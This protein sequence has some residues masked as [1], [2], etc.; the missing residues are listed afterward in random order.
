MSNAEH[1]IENAICTI[2]RGESFEDFAAD[3][4]NQIMSET[5]GVKLESVWDMAQYVIYTYCKHLR[6]VAKEAMKE[7][8]DMRNLYK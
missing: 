4:H 7:V 6:D 2:E 1:L 8:R 3:S 5:D